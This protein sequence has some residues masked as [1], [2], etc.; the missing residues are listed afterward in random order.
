MIVHWPLAF[1]SPPVLSHVPPVIVPTPDS[2]ART[3]TP[4]AATKPSSFA[5]VT[6]KVWAV[7]T[8][9]VPEVP[10]VIG[11]STYVFV[12]G[13]DPFGPEPIVAVAGSVSRVNVGPL[14]YVKTALPFAVNTPVAVE[15]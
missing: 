15:L 8:W 2:L 1:V 3:L 6:V 10:I 9:W 14:V 5:T 11:A 12:A 4:A 13:P 7:P